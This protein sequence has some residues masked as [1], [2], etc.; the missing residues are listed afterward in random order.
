[1]YGEGAV[2]TLDQS[3]DDDRRHIMINSPSG[4]PGAAYGGGSGIAAGRRSGTLRRCGSA[5]LSDTRRWWHVAT[6]GRRPG[7]GLRC[8]L[9]CRLRCPRCRR[10]RLRRNWRQGP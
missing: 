10:N 2:V 3:V 4:A 9:G 6:L 8:R 5:R 7:R 1:V